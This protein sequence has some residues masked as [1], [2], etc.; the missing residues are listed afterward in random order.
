MDSDCF[1]GKV[2]PTEI[3]LTTVASGKVQE[4]ATAFDVTK[5]EG[6]SRTYKRAREAYESLALVMEDSVRMVWQRQLE[7]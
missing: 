1:W 3:P 2:L 6:D 5:Y 4:F 7:G